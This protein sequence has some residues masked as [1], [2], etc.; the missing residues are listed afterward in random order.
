MDYK[1]AL[2]AVK[3]FS[4]MACVLVKM[5][6]AAFPSLNDITQAVGKQASGHYPPTRGLTYTVLPNRIKNL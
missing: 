4:K 1:N 3:L 6:P 2:L 5:D